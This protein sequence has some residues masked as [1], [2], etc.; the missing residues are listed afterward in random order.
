MTDKPLTSDDWCTPFWLARILGQFDL[1]PCSNE[2]SHIE[3]AIRCWLGGP[4]DLGDGLTFDWE[5]RS[6]FVNCPYSDV[7]PWARKL[8]E[9]SGPWV[10]L[11]KL[12]PT[13]KWWAELMRSMPTVAPFRKRIKFEGPLSMTANFPSVLVYSAW[14]PSRELA[15]HLWLATYQPLAATP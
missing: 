15:T 4:A 10:A 6:V 2:R 3:A 13:T 8:S 9:H 5:D 1:D 7:M 11:V 14:R 12:D